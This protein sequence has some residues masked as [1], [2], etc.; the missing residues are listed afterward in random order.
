E[1]SPDSQPGRRVR[2]LVR[3]AERDRK[4]AI[5]AGAEDK[6]RLPPSA[7]AKGVWLDHRP[8]TASEL[9]R[10]LRSK[11]SR[12]GRSRP[13]AQASARA[14]PVPASGGPSLVRSAGYRISERGK[15]GGCARD[16][17]RDAKGVSDRVGRC[18]RC[19]E[20]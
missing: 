13:A 18:R 15:G 10:E 14:N 3:A 12:P 19:G 8:G 2:L 4:Q 7:D 16:A 20:R 6:S 1:A 9:P 11:L 5:R 17:A